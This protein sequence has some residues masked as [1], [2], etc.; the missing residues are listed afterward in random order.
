MKKL[1]LILALFIPLFTFGQLDNDK[2]MKAVAEATNTDELAEGWT[3]GAGIGL[4]LGSLILIN[5]RA[6]AGDN[7]IGI[8]GASNFFA[9]YRKG[10]SAWDNI[11]SL[12]F[13]IQKIGSGILDPD[14]AEGKVPFQKNIDELRLNSKFGYKTSENSK[15]YYTVDFSMLSQLTPTWP[16]NFLRDVYDNGTPVSKLFSPATINFSVGMDY[17]PNDVYSI[18]FSPLAIKTIL[19]MDDDIAGTP[20]RNADGLIIG[21][22]HGNPIEG[23]GMG[24]VAS[25]DN[26]F[27]ALGASLRAIMTKKMWDDRISFTSNLL[28]FSNYL[29]NPQNIDIDWTNEF[30]VTIFSGLQFSMTANLFYDH[31][32]LVQ[33]TDLDAQGGVERDANGDPVLKRNVSLTFQPLIKYVKVF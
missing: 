12:N 22:L 32:V 1:T 23:D 20:V 10:R 14:I 4:D 26:A 5:P 2:R 25:F 19:V 3:V 11:A 21:S 15:Y 33:Q 27:F 28:L 29:D 16:G 8:G 6:G 13:A 24:N 7:R 18:Y 31:D 17:K 30:A 9:K